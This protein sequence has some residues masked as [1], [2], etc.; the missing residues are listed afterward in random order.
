M[1]RSPISF[2]LSL[3]SGCNKTENSLKYGRVQPVSHARKEDKLMYHRQLLIW[4]CVLLIT[5]GNITVASEKAMSLF[6]Q[7]IQELNTG[8]LDAARETFDR[9]TTIVPDFADAHYHLGLVYYQKTEYQKAIDAFTQTLK[10]LPRD[11]D[12]LIK[13]GLAS[14]KAGDANA[15]NL[16]AKRTFY[17]QSVEAYQTALEI[18]SHN[19]EALNNLGLAYQELG[20]FSEAITVY[21]KGLTL[22][23]D[24]P[25]LHANLAAA[26]DLQAGIYSLAAYQ[27]YKVGTRAKRA[28]RTEAAIAAWNQAITESP[29]YLQA[30]LQLAELYFQRAEYESA[31]RTYLSAIALVSESEL[32]QR[33]GTADIFYNLGNSYLYAQQLEAA[34]SAYQ[35]A[36]DLNPEM[37]SAWANMGT[38]LLEME[39][40]DAA[41]AACQSALKANASV[42]SQ[43][44]DAP[45]SPSALSA[46]EFARNTAQHI[47]DGEYTMQTYRIWRQGTSARNRGDIPTALKLWEQA[48]AL[49]PRY[50]M[51][52][53]NLAW[54]Y[55][56]LKRF[57]DAIQSCKTVQ[58]IRP[59]P[60][61]A[62]LLTFASELKAGKYPFEAYQMWEQGRRASAAGNLT[63]AVTLLLTA[64]ETGPEFASAYNTLAWLYADKL[65]T[66]LGEAERLARR[67]HE[68]APDATHIYDT[69]GWILHKQGRHIEALN[70]IKQALERTPNN[71]EY[72]YHASLAAMEI[73][74]PSQALKYLAEAI[75]LDKRFIRQAQTQSEFDSIRFTPAFRNIFP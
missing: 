30:Y 54:V 64:I 4:I 59:S 32:S 37:V 18:Q 19:V 13:L 60:Q 53:E 39:R 1:Y 74:Q 67:A 3:L 17:E 40:F 6:S 28:G 42:L 22:N 70:A 56:N 49:S 41:I 43:G 48:V 5:I 2:A 21:E 63:E 47:K 10:L 65:G 51:V 20:R 26:R 27:H 55:F 69:L 52:H 16:P 12:A 34:V 46:I 31:I 44:K 8:Q 68:L 75:A 7:G 25:Q 36:V 9:V 58:T 23:P 14:H 45:I 72:L 50:A 62:Q 11:T 24:L 66:N 73:G 61:V 29:K 15:I 71:A 38:V 33:A 57:D 35:Q